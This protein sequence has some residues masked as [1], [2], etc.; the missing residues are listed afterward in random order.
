MGSGED[1]SATHPSSGQGGSVALKR[2]RFLLKNRTI[3][4][5]A[6][7]SGFL[8]L[9]TPIA[10]LLHVD[11]LSMEASPVYRMLHASACEVPIQPLLNPPLLHPW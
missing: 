11:C 5:G 7:V 2:V 10:L 1:S 3:A 4:L 6:L 8:Y 9:G